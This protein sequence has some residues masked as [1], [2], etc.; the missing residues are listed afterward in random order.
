VT[1]PATGSAVEPQRLHAVRNAV[2]DAP[3]F[4]GSGLTEAN[5]AALLALADGAIVGS[6][7]MRDGRAGGGVDEERV[8]RLIRDS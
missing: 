8:R 4:I 6:A 7:F 3:L 5:A 1:G 2:P